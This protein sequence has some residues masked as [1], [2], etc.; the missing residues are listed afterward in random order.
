MACLDGP[1]IG[2][3][4]LRLQAIEL[5]L[6]RRRLAE[7]KITQ[8]YITKLIKIGQNWVIGNFK[9]DFLPQY[10]FQHQQ[11]FCKQFDRT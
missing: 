6:R 9:E 7:K 11:V 4:V 10:V 8:A 2:I 3:F 1:R 5:G